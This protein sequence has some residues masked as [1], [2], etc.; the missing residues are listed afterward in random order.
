[1]IDLSNKSACIRDYNNIVVPAATAYE[2]HRTYQF[3]NKSGWAITKYKGECI[4]PANAKGCDALFI[5]ELK[6]QKAV[7]LVELK[8]ADLN[9]AISQIDTTLNFLQISK[10][11]NLKF[12]HGRIVP[13]SGQKPE[14][15]S[16]NHKRLDI[17]LR[18]LGG[19][20]KIQSRLLSEAI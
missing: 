9:K 5:L 19:N 7:C 11:S 10:K 8:G 16:T 14:L 3:T 12:V 15:R 6:K 17:R 13:S 18:E 1:M 4:T 20:L 2:K